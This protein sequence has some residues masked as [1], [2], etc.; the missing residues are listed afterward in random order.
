MAKTLKIKM[1]HKQKSHMSWL[2]EKIKQ[3]ISTTSKEFRPPVLSLKLT[4]E[5]AWYNINI[6][7]DFN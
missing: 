6:L 1:D 3:L 4:Q 7:A 2:V 5:E